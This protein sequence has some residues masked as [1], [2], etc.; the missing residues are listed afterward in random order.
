[1]KQQMKK[2]FFAVLMAAIL[3]MTIAGSA[4]STFAAPSGN[5]TVRTALNMRSGMTTKANNVILV[6]PSGG[7][8]AIVSAEANNWYK[9]TY[10]GKTGYIKGGYFG[11]PSKSTSSSTTTKVMAENLNMRSSMDKSTPDNIIRVIGK[12]KTV[13]ILNAESNGWYKISYAGK[14][15]YIMGGHFTDDTSRVGAKDAEPTYKDLTTTS[16]VNFRTAPNGKVISVIPANTKVNNLT[17][18]GNWYKI[19]Y[20]GKTGYVYKNYVK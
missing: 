15:G 3:A 18:E 17:R 9:V 8:V 20:N 13:T 4:V 14:T 5:Q 11:T 16:A 1:M 6:I 10:S 7:T 19:K 2:R 12:G